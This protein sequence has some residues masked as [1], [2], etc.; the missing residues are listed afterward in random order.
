[1]MTLNPGSVRTISEALL[2]ASV[3]SATAIPI[4]A[5][6]RAG[7]SFTP[8]PVI[9]QMCFLSCNFFTIS[10]LCSGN[11]PANPSAFSISSSTGRPATFESLSCP[12]S[13]EE[14]YM[15]VP[16]P[17]RRPVSLAMAS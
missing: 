5:F 16:I 17:R 4:S 11:T 9:P 15:L 7:A 13:E 14:G 2:A 1:M 8:S 12:R 10:Y 6:L 3:A